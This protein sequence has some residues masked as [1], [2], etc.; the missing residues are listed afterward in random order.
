VVAAAADVTPVLQN[1]LVVHL[2]HVVVLLQS[3][4]VVHLLHAVVLLQNLLVVHLLHAV[5]L[6]LPHLA[7]AR[8]WLCHTRLLLRTVLQCRAI[9][10][11]L[12]Q[13]HR[14]LLLLK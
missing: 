10:L 4:L 2:H 9:Q 1:L 12:L 6:L 14:R 3:L 7:V 8:Q 13:Q 5:V 11:L